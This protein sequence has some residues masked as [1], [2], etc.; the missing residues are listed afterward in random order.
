LE[1]P[2]VSILRAEAPEPKLNGHGERY[3][4]LWLPIGWFVPVWINTNPVASEDFLLYKYVRS[5]V[6]PCTHNST[7]RGFV[8]TRFT[9]RF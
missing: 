4:Q 9:I 7:P 6:H 8:V 2:A 1:K 3:K 5:S